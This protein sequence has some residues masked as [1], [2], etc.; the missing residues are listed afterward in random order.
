[1]DFIIDFFFSMNLGAK[2]LLVIINWLSKG[3]FL[4]PMLLISAPAVAIAF[5]EC[6]IP[7]HEFLKAIISD[8]GT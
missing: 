1:M 2:M 7:H 3:V 8:R 5:M 4:I 6:Y